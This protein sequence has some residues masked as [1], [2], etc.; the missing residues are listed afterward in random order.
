[1]DGRTLKQKKDLLRVLVAVELPETALGRVIESAINQELQFDD[2]ANAG[3]VDTLLQAVD[4]MMGLVRQTKA[5]GVGSAAELAKIEAIVR[6][7]FDLTQTE[8]GWTRAT[9]KGGA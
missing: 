2:E 7:S 6:D 8:D 4:E 9:L 1:M 3:W 5:P